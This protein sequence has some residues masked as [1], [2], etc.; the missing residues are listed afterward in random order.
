MASD[1]VCPHL[2]K[3]LLIFAAAL[4]GL[5]LAFRAHFVLCIAKG[6][7][8]L[9]GVRS[10][11][12][13]LVDKLAYSAKAPQRGDIVVAREGNDL[14]VKRVVGLPGEEVELQQGKLHINQRQLTEEYAVESGWL[15]L[16]KGRLF[17]DKYALLGDNRSIPIALSVHAVVSKDQILGK[18]IYSV[19]LWPSG[20][21]RNSISP[22]E[23]A[24]SNP[25]NPIL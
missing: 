7:S 8:M 10:G 25:R 21:V 19:R 2:N 12:L 3:R 18:V 23:I 6:E 16:R 15:S 5:L 22:N 14:I 11:D 1:H 24:Q 20:G 13:I 17:D 9:P 4:V